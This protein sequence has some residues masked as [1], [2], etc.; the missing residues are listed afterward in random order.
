MTRPGR[1]STDGQGTYL[2]AVEATLGADIDYAM[3]VKQYG[4]PAD[5]EIRYGPG[6]SIGAQKFRIQGDPDPDPISTSYIER[7]NLTMRMSMGRMT[8]LTNALSKKVQNLE[9]ARRCTPCSTTWGAFHK[10]LG[11]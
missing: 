1:L 3:L 10:T 7:Q 8:R 11:A 6:E 9:A 4:K 2:H 5:P